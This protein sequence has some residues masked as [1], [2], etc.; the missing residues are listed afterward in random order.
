M[1]HMICVPFKKPL[2]SQAHEDILP[3]LLLEDHVDSCSG[4]FCLFF[5]AT[6]C[7]MQYLS[8]PSKDRTC[9]PCSGNTYS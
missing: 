3:H 2:L 1:A 5:F 6:Q 8:F 4:V 9:T 7:G